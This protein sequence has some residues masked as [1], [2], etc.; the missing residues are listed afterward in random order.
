MCVGAALLTRFSFL[1]HKNVWTT[2]KLPQ[3]ST[4]V[5]LT[6]HTFVR[7]HN[8][9]QPA[10]P[11]QTSCSRW[12]WTCAGVCTCDTSWV[13]WGAWTTDPV[14]VS[15]CDPALRSTVGLLLQRQT[16]VHIWFSTGS[17]RCLM[18]L[19]PLSSLWSLFLWAAESVCVFLPAG[20]G[21]QTSAAAEKIQRSG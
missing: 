1:S 15:V 13:S 14:C 18:L 10:A 6:T 3:A 20:R 8:E 9:P 2:V 16:E 12:M 21:N 19:W 7:W 5:T 17:C 4:P 11:N